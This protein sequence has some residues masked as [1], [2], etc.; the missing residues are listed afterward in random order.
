MGGGPVS[1]GSVST[2][3]RGGAENGASI[4]RRGA[5]TL[6][7]TPRLEEGRVWVWGRRT[8]RT[9]SLGIGVGRAVYASCAGRAWRGRR[10]RRRT[11]ASFSA[12][13]RLCGEAGA[14]V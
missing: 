7:K 6:R 5:E 11:S 1:T 12:S 14:R 13:Q 8:A 9:G 2:R 3:G 4:H 10:T